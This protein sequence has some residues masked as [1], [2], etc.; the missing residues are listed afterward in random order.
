MKIIEFPPASAP[1]A[2]IAAFLREI[3]D[4]IETGEFKGA[5]KVFGI[6]ECEGEDEDRLYATFHKGGPQ[7][8]KLE[9]HGLI[10]IAAQIFYSAHFGGE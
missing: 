4:E 10:Q 1:D 2:D 9:A 8:T 3:A 5:S 7:F 6:L